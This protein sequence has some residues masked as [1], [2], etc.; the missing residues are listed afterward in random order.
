MYPEGGFSVIT[1]KTKYMCIAN[2]GTNI[3]SIHCNHLFSYISREKYFSQW[4][5]KLSCKDHLAYYNEIDLQH[6]I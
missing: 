1:A 6:G 2:L 5:Q 4:Q 3:I